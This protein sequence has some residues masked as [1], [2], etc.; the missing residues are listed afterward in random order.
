M[1][2]T[3][4][5]D[6]LERAL[7]AALP[8]EHQAQAAA[9]ARA[10]VARRLDPA[11][12]PALRAL[13]GQELASGDALIA[14]GSGSQLGDVTMAGDVVGG[15]KITISV[16]APTSSLTSQERRN[17]QAMIQKVHA[18]WVD[19]LLSDAFAETPRLELALHEAPHTVVNALA[20]HVQE[21]R[22][23]TPSAPLTSPIPSIFDTSQGALLILGDAGSGKTLLLLDLARHLLARA[24]TD[25]SQGIPVV[26]HLSSWSPRRDAGLDLWLLDEL[27]NKYD[28]P[29]TIAASWIASDALIP[30]LDGLDEVN[31][32][33]QESCVAAINTYHQTH[34]TPLVVCSR[35][36]PY[37]RLA[38]RLRL[39]RAIQIQPLDD[40]QIHAYL[41]SLGLQSQQA[42]ALLPPAII[43]L[44]RTPLMLRVVVLAY[45]TPGA[46]F[47]GTIRVEQ[48]WETFIRVV[49]SRRALNRNYPPMQTLLWLRTLG[50][51]MR[52]LG[53]QTL[54]IEHLQEEWLRTPALRYWYGLVDRGLGL[55]VGALMALVLVAS[56]V[57]IAQSAGGLPF[58]WHQ[59]WRISMP[60]AVA[61][62]LITIGF[63]GD[64]PV[65]TPWETLRRRL[66]PA[67]L[68]GVCVGTLGGL[69][70][71]YMFQLPNG[72]RT[73][74]VVG[75][76][77]A[78][79]GALAG[80]TG[81][82]SRR[83]VP[84]ESLRW[85][86]R[87]S[88]Q[89]MAIGVL[90]GALLGQLAGSLQQDMGGGIFLQLYNA[91]GG[92]RGLALAGV[93][94]GGI[95]GLLGGGSVSKLSESMLPNE[96]IRRSLQLALRFGLIGGLTCGAVV[97]S[98]LGLAGEMGFAATLG[99]GSALTGGLIVG[100]AYG[101][102]A[103]ISHYALRLV[104]WASREAPLRLA[105]FC[106]S[107][108]DRLLLRRVGGGYIFTHRLLM[109]H[110]ATMTD[111]DIARLSAEI[112]DG[113]R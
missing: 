29:R 14:F 100:L 86:W 45:G 90:I 84:T 20:E 69:A 58:G 61:C 68:G 4:T 23:T 103:C 48:I 43:E 66:V 28:V 40:S 17:R 111:E 44:L 15:N 24:S 60:A 25:D 67:I 101:G 47:P 94:C 87:Q 79:S 10:L 22:R 77:G 8:P 54:R 31:T 59:G 102:Y 65:G 80:S 37:A 96:G 6:D 16:A 108:V 5:T 63:G 32:T 27:T 78:L 93:L 26:L 38:A 76:F 75:V 83:I 64:P 36:A 107:G 92:S 91:V 19:G 53:Q 18:I 39:N 57:A 52:R 99:V 42:A 7:C 62:I 110:F 106:D 3:L 72:A 41:A 104:F 70:Y 34:L 82:R 85:S 51:A 49:L 98:L 109:E 1:S 55:A 74:I 13:A 50:R 89:G 73:G 9:L 71:T 46:S 105:R 21:L 81:L 35:T 95:I 11:L 112:Q 56:C 113:V 33:Y 30:L 2:P 88:L 97:W 12:R